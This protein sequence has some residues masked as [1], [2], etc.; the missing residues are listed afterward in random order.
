MARIVFTGLS[1]QIVENQAM[2]LGDPPRD[3]DNATAEHLIGAGLA[4]KAPDTRNKRTPS[5]GDNQQSEE[6]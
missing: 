1:P 4:V 2:A 6:D 3:I 5:P